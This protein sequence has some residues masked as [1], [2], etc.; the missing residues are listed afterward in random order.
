VDTKPDE[1]FTATLRTLQKGAS[2]ASVNYRFVLAVFSF[3]GFVWAAGAFWEGLTGKIDR[4]EQ[5]VAELTTKI[6][7]L[8]TRDTSAAVLQ[9]RVNDLERRVDEQS[10]KWERAEEGADINVRRKHQ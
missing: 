7:S 8:P 5:R 3:I 2:W 4:L 6:D 10:R 1:T 9:E